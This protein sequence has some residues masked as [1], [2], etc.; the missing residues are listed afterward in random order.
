MNVRDLIL[1]LLIARVAGDDNSVTEFLATFDGSTIDVDVPEEVLVALEQLNVGN[2]LTRYL[3]W[4]HA[5][6]TFANVI[7]DDF[8][9]SEGNEK[10]DD[11]RF[12]AAAVDV[13]G[14][15]QPPD[16]A[17]DGTLL[18][19]SIAITES[20]AGVAQMSHKYKEGTDITPHIHWVKPTAGTGNVVWQFR[21]RW[22]NVGDVFPAW[23]SWIEATDAV[24]PSNDAD[25]HSIATFGD[26]DGTDK[27]ISSFLIWQIQRDPTHGSDDYTADD[28]K[29]MEFDIHYQIDTI[30]SDHEFIK[31][32]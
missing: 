4:L 7:L 14:Q 6:P 12:P 5:N 1:H 31:D 25:R 23:S 17:D 24:G 11:L 32:S 29:F 20:I 30:G 21:Y 22:A 26:L 28:A 15:S 3:D 27:R 19:D 16:P 8:T 9:F 2:S 18:F 13:V 10:W